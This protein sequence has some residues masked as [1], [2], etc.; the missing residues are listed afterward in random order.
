MSL[1]A[2]QEKC[3]RRIYRLKDTLRVIQEQSRP[4]YW[5]PLIGVSLQG[6]IY[7]F[8]ILSIVALTV[9]IALAP[10]Y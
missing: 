9:F 5:F 6:F 8:S 4:I 10:V 7:L 2:L 1:D 3:M